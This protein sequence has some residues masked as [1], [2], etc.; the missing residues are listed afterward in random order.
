MAISNK[1]QTK[2]ITAQRKSSK[3]SQVIEKFNQ[4]PR[5]NDVRATNQQDIEIKIAK[6]QNLKEEAYRLIYQTYLEKAILK[7]MP[8]KCGIQLMIF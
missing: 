2:R 8:L 7:K 6:D 4:F 3:V 5:S 1:G